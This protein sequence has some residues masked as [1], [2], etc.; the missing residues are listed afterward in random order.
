MEKQHTGN[1]STVSD[2]IFIADF[3]A[4]DVTGGAELHDDVVISHLK[5]SGILH[6]KIRSQQVDVEYLSKNKDKRFMIGNFAG[7]SFECLVYLASNCKYLL[8]EHDYKFV[9]S[10]NPI[11]F[12]NFV[13][14]KRNII[15]INFYKNAMK[16]VCLSGMHRKIFQDNLGFENLE[17]INCSMWTDDS[18]DKILD[19]LGNEK[20]DKMAVI[21]SPNRLKKTKEAAEF[22]KSRGLEFDLIASRDYYE[23][24]KMLSR[25]SGLVFMTGHPEPTPRVAIEAKM[26]DCKFV[27]QK[28]LIGVAHE[29]YF[30]LSGAHMVERVREMRDDALV[31][32]KDWLYEV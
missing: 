26:L 25:Y 4:G 28:N 32:I 5:A 8:Y 1:G 31:K 24:L 11:A 20:L 14:P 21:N 12:P 3:F 16:V 10:R 2:V 27:S 29:D 9:D 7:L 23:F 19:M 15:N 6:S 18:L 17:N 22:C 30:D 13:V